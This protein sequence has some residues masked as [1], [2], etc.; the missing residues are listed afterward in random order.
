MKKKK[1]EWEEYPPLA[2]FVPTVGR[3][4]RRDEDGAVLPF[5]CMVACSELLIT[6]ILL[7]ARVGRGG[8][9]CELLS[10][11]LAKSGDLLV[12]A[13]PC[14]SGLAPLRV[15][16]RADLGG[17][18][19]ILELTSRGP[20]LRAGVVVGDEGQFRQHVLPEG[21]VVGTDGLHASCKVLQLL[22]EVRVLLEVALEVLALPHQIL[23]GPLPH[24][25]EVRLKA[26]GEVGKGPD[27]VLKLRGRVNLIHQTLVLLESEE[28]EVEPNLVD[29]HQRLFHLP[30]RQ[31][32]GAHLPDDLE[33]LL[34]RT[35][36]HEERVAELLLVGGLALRL[37]VGPLLAAPLQQLRVVLDKLLHGRG[38]VLPPLLLVLSPLLPL[39]GGLGDGVKQVLNGLD[40]HVSRGDTLLGQSLGGLLQ[41]RQRGLSS[42]PALLKPCVDLRLQALE[43]LVGGVVH[44]ETVFSL[45]T[46]GVKPRVAHPRPL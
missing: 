31:E 4:R 36:V 14:L 5:E 37:E 11:E 21:L 32:G 24:S 15:T 29:L 13:L 42:L 46:G 34:H 39:L 44:V 2:P 10:D 27:L 43:L 30:V 17:L 28:L 3:R 19:R 1:R 16:P 7:R 33:V 25:V 8:Q 40:R 41:P 12:E 38:L 9:G 18:L 22:G 35:A 20:V 6:L 23:L 45:R 26:S